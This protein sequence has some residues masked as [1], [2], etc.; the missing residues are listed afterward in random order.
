MGIMEEIERA[1]RNMAVTRLVVFTLAFAVILGLVLTS[2]LPAEVSDSE[3][4]NITISDSNVTI[5]ER[6]REAKSYVSDDGNLCWKNVYEVDVTLCLNWSSKGGMEDDGY[7]TKVTVTV[8]TSR[9][10]NLNLSWHHGYFDVRD[11]EYD[12][13][14]SFTEDFTLTYTIP[15]VSNGSEIDIRVEF[16]WH[17]YKVTKY[18]QGFRGSCRGDEFEITKIFEDSVMTEGS[19]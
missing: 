3:I 7:F 12:V 8:V 15:G 1:R 17:I 16:G 13:G 19:G 18:T 5:K 14:K 11:Y 6:S 2:F 10:Q 4:P 9:D